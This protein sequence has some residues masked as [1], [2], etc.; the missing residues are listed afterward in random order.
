MLNSLKNKIVL[1]FN[2]AAD[3]FKA[4]GGRAFT[5]D[6]ALRRLAGEY[7]NG[8]TNWVL[9]GDLEEI[10]TGIDH[11]NATRLERGIPAITVK[12]ETAASEALT[13]MMDAGLHRTTPIGPADF[14]GIRLSFDNCGHIDAAHVYDVIDS[15]L[16]LSGRDALGTEMSERHYLGF[17]NTDKLAE[18]LRAFSGQMMRAE[19]LK[20]Y[21]HPFPY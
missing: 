16:D 1:A 2:N 3:F 8:A 18:T 13:G 17:K 21:A 12:L 11:I 9:A 15:Y 4:D 10:L 7:K 5:D 14:G 6:A 19:S 20:W